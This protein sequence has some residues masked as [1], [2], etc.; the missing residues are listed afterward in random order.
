MFT[1]KPEKFFPI[2]L[3]NTQLFRLYRF[4][5][6]ILVLSSLHVFTQAKIFW[7]K[8]LSNTLF[9]FEYGFD[10]QKWFAFWCLNIASFRKILLGW[11]TESQLKKCTCYHFTNRMIRWSKKYFNFIITFNQ[12]FTVC[13]LCHGIL[14]QKM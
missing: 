4:V 2:Y 14:T 6:G 5:L 12:M 10:I 13:F 1:Y 3:N 9:E 11:H 8:T 7:L